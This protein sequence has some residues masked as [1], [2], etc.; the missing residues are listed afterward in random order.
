MKEK[1]LKDIHYVGDIVD[2]T[3]LRLIKT[4]EK[5]KDQDINLCISSYGGDVLAGYHFLD[6][7]KQIK[8]IKRCTALSN[9]MSMGA[10]IWLSF[11]IE[12]RFIY[13]TSILMFHRA[14]SYNESGSDSQSMERERKYLEV[15]DKRS[16]D[17]IVKNSNLNKKQTLELLDSEAYL[18]KQH[19]LKNK[20]ILKENVISKRIK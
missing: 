2:Y 8:N 18:E 6:Y 20:M 12:K 17:L 16:I 5:H 7:L 14:K 9:A 3:V 10:F 13:N 11:P 1:K 4:L 19:L 15:M